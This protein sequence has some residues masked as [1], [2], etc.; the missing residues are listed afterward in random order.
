[1]LKNQKEHP[2]FNPDHLIDTVKEWLGERT[3]CSLAQRLCVGKSTISKLRHCSVR[4]SSELLIGMHEETGLSIRELRMLGGDFRLHTGKT[5][6]MVPPASV[7]QLLS[8]PA[9]VCA[10]MARTRKR[11]AARTSFY[12]VKNTYKTCQ[13][14]FQP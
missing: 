8:D 11:I 13:M 10:E 4:V 2:D 5:A 12:M 14:K 6:Q 7:W 3:D 9:R 1:M